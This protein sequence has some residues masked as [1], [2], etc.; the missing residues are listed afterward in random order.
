MT[1]LR[2]TSLCLS[3]AL[4]ASASAFAAPLSGTFASPLGDLAVT[5]KDGIVTGRV[6]DAKNA[7]GFP[8]GT[9]VLDGSRLDDSITGNL[10]ACK[11]G[12]GCAGPVDG[13]V[14][15]LVAKGGTV[16]S[17]AVHFDAGACKTPVAG[18]GIALK[19]IGGAAAGAKADKP[20][21]PKA[22][23][24][25]KV[26]KQTPRQRA[27]ALAIEGKKLLESGAEGSVE[28]AREK[29]KEAVSVDPDYAEGFIGIGATFVM[30]QRFD[31]AL[32]HYKK[33]IEVNPSYPDAYYNIACV[34]AIKNDPEQ[35]LR[36][37]RIS[38]LNGWAQVDLLA[39]D[40]DLKNLHGNEEFEKMKKGL[41]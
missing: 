34:Y 9:A 14:M 15:L 12:D 1:M 32:E 7:C 36:Y 2:S 29:F 6:V 8:K 25:P 40:P 39:N 17:G 33:A 21:P 5:E 28:E 3:F 23:K 30:R 11:V 24:D 31:E 4:L 18:D 20:K 22:E 27:Q 19:K 37:L 26:G 16:L 41:L 10:R 38:F 13:A 35:A